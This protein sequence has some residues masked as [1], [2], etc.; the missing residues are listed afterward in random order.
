MQYYVMIYDTLKLLL[1]IAMNK[2]ILC[3]C[4]ADVYGLTYLS[5]STTNSAWLRTDARTVLL[6]NIREYQSSRPHHDSIFIRLPAINWQF[7]HISRSHTVIRHSLSLPSRHRTRSLNIYV[8]LYTTLC[9]WPACAEY[10]CIQ[11]IRGFYAM[12][13][14]V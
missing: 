1:N 14:F 12:I 2:S 6:Y 3:I 13:H 4:H 5:V 9:F 10:Y 8:I 7:H 11:C